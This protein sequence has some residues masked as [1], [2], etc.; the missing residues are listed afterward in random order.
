MQLFMKNK[1]WVAVVTGG[2]QAVLGQWEGWRPAGRGGLAWERRCLFLGCPL[3]ACLG[4]SFSFFHAQFQ[5]HLL[6]DTSPGWS[7]S[8]PDFTGH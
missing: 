7:R 6:H 1:Y 2:M 4:I 8:L 5:G 3:P